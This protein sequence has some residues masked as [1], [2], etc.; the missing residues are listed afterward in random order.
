MI[1]LVKFGKIAQVITHAIADF[2]APLHWRL[3]NAILSFFF[4]CGSLLGSEIIY[5]TFFPFMFWNID[6]TLGRRLVYQ[7]STMMYVGQGLKVH[8]HIT[9]SRAGPS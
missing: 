2:L 7:W 4:H 6:A 5:I 1:L 3:L 8:C 9:A